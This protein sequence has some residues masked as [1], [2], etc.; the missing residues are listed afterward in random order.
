MSGGYPV[1]LSELLQRDLGGANP[2]IAGLAS[3][4]DEVLP[5]YLFAALKG[6]ENDG[7]SFIGEALSRGAAAVLMRPGVPALEGAIAITDDNPRRALALLAARF[8]GGQPATVAA[9]TGTNGKT[10][11]ACF[12]RQIWEALGYP[13][14]SVG[15]LGVV[16]AGHND[17]IER[18]TPQPVDLHRVLAQLAEEGVDHAVLEGSSH[19]LDQH[20]MDGVTVSAAA[21]TNLSRDHFD[22]HPTVEDYF[23][24]KMRLFTDVMAPGGVAVLNADVRE[25]PESAQLCRDR[26]HRVLSYGRHGANLRV[27][28][29]KPNGT[30]Q[31]I[32][33][34]FEGNKHSLRVPL[35]GE[36]QGWNALCAL[37]LVVGGGADPE[38]AVA[39]LSNLK[40]VPGR[41]QEVAELNGGRVF[42]DYAH[43][44]DAL[45]SCLRAL[46]PHA[47]NRL[48]VVFG[49]GGDRDRGKRPEMGRIACTFADRIVVTDDNP[50]REDPARIRA[51]VLAGC[52]R[53]VEV[54]G[55]AEAIRVAVGGLDSGDVLL[56]SGKGHET[57]Q[58]IGDEVL[59]FDDAVYAQAA[60]EEVARVGA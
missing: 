24:A 34:A 49:C 44:P 23:A 35:V 56:I 26:G 55:R 33:L 10:S 11:V 20:R 43:T 46:R 29:H 15:T 14:A 42:I 5:G 57:E 51:E 6:G 58:I 21:F 12:T 40:G 50:R 19:G 37:G 48:T 22:Y 32:D 41:V 17:K 7:A 39:A 16:G 38:A 4:S 36:F 52:D 53:A 18:T 30:G 31:Y 9:V 25:Y 2:D 47:R 27:L 60:A 54:P 8:F 3:H 59:P 1:R 13:A 28:G 45:E